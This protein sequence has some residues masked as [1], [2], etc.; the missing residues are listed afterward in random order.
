VS[1]LVLMTGATGFVGRRLLRVWLE[2]TSA[3][4]VVLTRPQ[5]GDATAARCG[6]AVPELAEDFS[7]RVTAVAADL[8][9]PGLGLSSALRNELTTA[10]THIVHCGGLVRFDVP[11][12]DARAANTTGT[13]AMLDLA[14][15]CP[16]LRRFDHISTAFVAGC[17]RGVVREDEHD[18][19]QQHHNGYERSKLEA[20]LLVRGAAGDLPVAIHRPSI[21]TCDTRT[22]ELAPFGAV[23]RLLGA[24]A[25]GNLMALPGRP[26]ARLDL[27]PVD[28][29]ADAVF[30]VAADPGSV[31]GCFHLAA[32]PDRSP[33]LGEVRDLAAE[34]F[35]RPPLL[36]GGDPSSLPSALRAEVELYAPYL[37][38]DLA[39]AVTGADTFLAKAGVDLPNLAEYFAIMARGVRLLIRQMRRPHRGQ[40]RSIP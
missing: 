6:V 5:N 19:G 38:C 4:V 22:G 34:H 36:I 14:R 11:L 15:Q 1:E 28:F 40:P 33:E 9:D 12:A 37:T 31:G 29:V 17:R 26:D 16:R 32:G 39:F 13:A 2:K 23:A 7:R 8:T 27:V 10:V 3:R 24:Y 30:A 35:Q 18:R 25:A 21:V 20:E